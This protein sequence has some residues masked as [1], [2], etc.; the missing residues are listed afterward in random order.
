[1]LAGKD[2]V[3][4]RC[5]VFTA[6]HWQNGRNIEVCGRS[7]MLTVLLK[8]DAENNFGD[9]QGYSDAVV[10]C[11][12]PLVERQHYQQIWQEAADLPKT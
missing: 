11:H 6:L 7:Q 5:G 3:W 8:S 2:P 12:P 9:L 4:R 1:M 10:F